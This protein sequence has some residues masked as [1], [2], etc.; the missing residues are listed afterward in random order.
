MASKYIES[1]LKNLP[2]SGN[3]SFVY[4]ELLQAVT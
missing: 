1:L 4:L 3:I 2:S